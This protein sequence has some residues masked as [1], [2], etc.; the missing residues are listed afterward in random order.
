[1]KRIL[2]SLSIA[3]LT[4]CPSFG[5]VLLEGSLEQLHELRRATV[6]FDYSKAKIHGMTE[7]AFSVHEKD[8]DIDRSSIEDLF[9]E[10]LNAETEGYIIFGNFEKSIPVLVVRIL[11]INTSGDWTCECELVDED[12]NSLAKIDGP[13]RKGGKIGTALNL[14][15]DG[16]EHNGEALGKFMKACMKDL[17]DP[18]SSSKSPIQKIREKIN[19]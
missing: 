16:A 19:I 11:T 13:A 15:K 18:S 7:E 12:G 10:E 9:V 14:I 1:M 4:I 6:E 17:E 3:L 2:I 5:Q 8:W